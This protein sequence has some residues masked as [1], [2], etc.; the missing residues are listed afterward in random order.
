MIW[1]LVKRDPAWRAA[2][3][4]VAAGAAICLALPR[5]IIVLFPL[6]SVAWFRGQPHERATLFQAALPIGACDLWLARVISF[7]ALAWFPVAGGVTMLLLA[8][9]PLGDAVT[10]M[11]IGAGLTVSVLALQ[12]WRVRELEA[13]VWARILAVAVLCVFIALAKFMAPAGVLMLCGATGAVLFWNIWRQLPPAFEVLPAKVT[14]EVSS[15]VTLTAPALV[16]SP[17]L[18]SLFPPKVWLFLLIIL[19]QFGS[20]QWLMVAVFW[21]GPIQSALGQASWAGSLPVRR[22]AL[23]SA[24]VLPGISSVLLAFLL[25]GLFTRNQTPIQFDWLNAHNAS[26]VRTPVEFWRVAPQ[27][28]APLIQSPWQESW[29]PQIVRIG[30]LA[31]YNPY[32]MGPDNSRRFFEWQYLRATVAVYG[33]Q[34]PFEDYKRL[35]S[36]RPLNRQARLMLLNLGAIVCWVILLVDVMLIAMHWRIG[37]IDHGRGVIVWLIWVPVFCPILFDVLTTWTPSGPVSTTLLNAVLLRVS[38]ALPDGLPA[39]ALAAALPVT[40]LCRTAARL[41]RGVEMQRPAAA[42][43]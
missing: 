6:V 34:I 26:A 38:A 1:Q 17:I 31:V 22:N 9:K 10:L 11:E 36:L 35:A 24:I 13:P 27:G 3:F 12:S 7:L 5:E 19:L 39:V 32:G 20:N 25:H 37:R 14:S 41:F 28:K 40:L 43:S 29:Q 30:G 18:R 15:Q 8:G 16:W 2:Q 33:H 23:P 4:C 42:R 21:V